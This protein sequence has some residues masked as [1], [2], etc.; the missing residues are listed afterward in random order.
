M[1]FLEERL[2]TQ[3]LTAL[4]C[5]LVMILLL[6]MAP[7]SL[8]LGA[9]PQAAG[10]S[11]AA[12]TGTVWRGRM[13]DAAIGGVRL[14]DLQVGVSPLSLLLARVS[15]GFQGQT[16]RGELVLRPR[17]TRLIK[18]DADLPLT[19]LLAGGGVNGRASLRDFDLDLLGG[20]CERAGGAV[21]LDQLSL[22]ALELPGLMLSG[23]PSCGGEDLVIP[24]SGQA[25]GVD[26]AADLRVSPQGV[27]RIDLILRTTRPEVGLAL[28][29][30]GA[31]T[32][33]DGHL[34]QLTGRLGVS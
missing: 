24:M 2:S 18:V 1:R 33:A 16:V 26:V 29:A 4:F 19:A 13:S 34:I 20:R 17:H 32:T 12:V 22:G 15:L 31:Q 21:S 5:A 7:L 27:Y 30:A 28:G 3:T 6:A 8:A 25:D 9:R 11:A 10:L 23:A 14:G